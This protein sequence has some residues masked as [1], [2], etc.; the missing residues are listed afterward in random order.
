LALH[1]DSLKSYE[2]GG[3]VEKKKY[4]ARVTLTREQCSRLLELTE[5]TKVPLA[6][7]IREG[8]ELVLER[9]QHQLPGQIS[10]LPE[11]G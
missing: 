5:E 3:I 6:E 8:I 1:S 11:D 4:P 10:L 2:L 9:H 7:Y